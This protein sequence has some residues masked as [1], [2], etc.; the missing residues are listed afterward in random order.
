MFLMLML[1][2][3]GFKI[4]RANSCGRMELIY[5]AIQAGQGDPNSV[6]GPALPMILG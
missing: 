4:L 6:S 1:L 5:Q 3:E 2:G